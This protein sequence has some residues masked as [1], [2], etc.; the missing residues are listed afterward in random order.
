M[1]IQVE[2]PVEFEDTTN[3]MDV[4]DLFGC[5][6]NYINTLFFLLLFIIM[7]ILLFI[8]SDDVQISKKGKSLKEKVLKWDIK[9][10]A[11]SILVLIIIL[12]IGKSC[13]NNSKSDNS[14]AMQDTLALPDEIAVDCVA[15]APVEDTCLVEASY[16]EL[17][18][19]SISDAENKKSKG[20]SAF[21]K[22]KQ[23][24]QQGDEGINASFSK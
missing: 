11:I 5:T 10:M 21:G 8:F 23:E 16:D 1:K 3:L 7:S 20:M 17:I 6:F 18:N 2:I 4:V 22:A 9:L 12:I 13:N 19:D 24:L 14:K 15:V